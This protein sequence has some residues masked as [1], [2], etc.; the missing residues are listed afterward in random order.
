[1]SDL[2]HKE[3]NHLF[4]HEYGKLVALLTKVFGATN[5]AF[6]EDVAQDTLLKAL[7]SWKL[8]GIPQ[9]P[10]AWLYTVARNRALDLLRK[11]KHEEAFVRH[12]NPL[13]TSE[14]TASLTLEEAFKN[15]VLE[16]EQLRMMFICC[17]PSISEDAQAALILKTLCGF[18]VA[19]IASAFLTNQETITKRLFR[20]REKLREATISFDVP[21]ATELSERLESVLTAVYLLFNEGYHATHNSLLIR[22]DLVEEA[23]RLGYLLT[24]N[25]RTKTT[26]TLA[27][28]ALMCF[29]A[30]R[31]YSRIDSIGTFIP[32]KEQDR[33]QWNQELIQKGISF[34]QQASQGE[35][36][37]AYH[38]EAAIA[39]E[40]CIA[41]GYDNTNWESID[42]LYAKLM[43]VRPAPL[44]TFQHAII[45][46]ERFGP[47]AG[48]QHMISL[49]NDPA[50]STHHF[51]F[52]AKG[53]WLAQLNR[54]TEARVQFQ[55]ALHLAQ[56]PSEKKFIQSKIDTLPSL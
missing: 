31:L 25:N 24:K 16:D 8:K 45:K 6:V 54:N 55:K 48:L 23:L 42:Q 51:F 39:Y 40:H 11:K 12:L 7:E 17:H 4:R 14:Y 32:L 19:E 36:L 47:E 10:S 46:A 15:S 28:L 13:L 2:I 27:L 5:L 33:S 30:A 41:P 22:E 1:M 56:V 44:I 37:S 3:L 26:N 38:L 29:H 49:E 20:A 9:N 34:L 50:L 21:P 52:T 43:Q 18:S 35:T 53:M